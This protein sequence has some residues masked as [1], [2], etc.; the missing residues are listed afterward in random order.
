LKILTLNLRHHRDRWAERFPLVVDVIHRHRPDLIGFQEVWRPID[1]ADAIL[2]RVPELALE[3]KVV[4]KQGDFG[5][6]GIAIASRY[7]I[8]SHQSL[9]LPGGERVA[10]RAL[11]DVDGVRFCF[12]NTHLH[13]KPV[14][15]RIRL[16][17][18]QALLQWLCDTDHP[19]ILTGDM[20]AQPQS[21]TILA[22]KGPYQSAYEAVHG[23][24]PQATFPTP[25]VSNFHPDQGSVI[26]Y[27]FFARDNLQAKAASIVA[28]RPH[29]EDETLYPSDHFGIL[30]AIEFVPSTPSPK[31]MGER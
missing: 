7:P 18:M 12:A 16:P 20:N 9:D 3:L 22:A 17:Q 19:T 26:D 6:E 1:Q 29:P 30:A 2:E 24:E 23:S 25:L 15:E 11:V 5:R 13:D 4:P 28:N 14:D 10:Q 27:I 31:M 21:T 8:I